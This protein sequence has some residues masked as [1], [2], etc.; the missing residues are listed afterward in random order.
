MI[1]QEIQNKIIEVG[2]ESTTVQRFGNF[3]LVDE[4]LQF[5]KYSK[6]TYSNPVVYGFLVQETN[7][8][9]YIGFSTN[10]L[11]RMRYY[12]CSNKRTTYHSDIRKTLTILDKVKQGFTVEVFVYSINNIMNNE[13]E[14]INSKLLELTLELEKILIGYYKPILNTQHIGNNNGETLQ[15]YSKG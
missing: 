2:I 4:N 3:D 14:S 10:V 7:E 11:N 12:R 15:H 9:I 6:T 5:I 1:I 8:L 13:V